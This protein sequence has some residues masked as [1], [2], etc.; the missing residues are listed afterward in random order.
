MTRAGRFSVKYFLRG[1]KVSMFFF[2]RESFFFIDYEN[3]YVTNPCEVS[4]GDTLT[5][6]RSPWITLILCF[7]M[8]PESTPRTITL[9]SHSISM[10]PRP[11]TRVTIPS[12]SIKSPL[13]K[14]LLSV[15]EI[16]FRHS[17]DYTLIS[18]QVSGSLVS[19]SRNKRLSES[20]TCSNSTGLTFFTIHSRALFPA[21]D[22]CL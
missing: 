14:M 8:R 11:I 4:Y 9:F 6:T 19:C 5:L 12:S 3:R 2:K 21:F 10:V 15:D 18:Q 16:V 17:S 22:D 20:S 7:F 1:R 13:L